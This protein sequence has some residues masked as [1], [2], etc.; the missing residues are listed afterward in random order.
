M[1]LTEPTAVVISTLLPDLTANYIAA[2]AER[3]RIEKLVEEMVSRETILKDAIISK[4]REQGITKLGCE[5][6]TVKMAELIEPVATDWQQVWDHVQKTGHFDL[7]HRRLANLAVK[8][9]WEH[10]EEIPGVT[11]TTVFK[12]TVSK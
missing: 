11:S 7:L 12:L 10:G 5:A 2:R 6:G 1:A 8:A 4:M 3:L 9:R